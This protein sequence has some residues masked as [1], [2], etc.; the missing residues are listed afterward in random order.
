M[1]RTL[2]IVLVAVIGGLVLLGAVIAIVVAA[3]RSQRPRL[4]D[5]AFAGAPVAHGVVV[6]RKFAFIKVGNS[7][8]YRV[9]YQLHTPQGQQFTGWETVYLSIMEMDRFAVGTRHRVAYLPGG[10]T[11]AVRSIPGPPPGVR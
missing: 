1:L 7:R 4:A 9:T 2:L 8:K 6:E 10:Q 5:S 11:S 3:V